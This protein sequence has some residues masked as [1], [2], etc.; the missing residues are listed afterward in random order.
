[1]PTDPAPFSSGD[2]S[3]S[4]T[5]ADEPF[6]L[7]RPPALSGW[8]SRSS[9]F[10]ARRCRDHERALPSG[11]TPTAL[12]SHGS[13]PSAAVTLTGLVNLLVEIQLEVDNK[14]SPEVG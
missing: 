3:Q 9:F 5:D 14:F 1:M 8:P 12:D 4:P 7:A 2:D 13:T 10:Y 11:L 6:S